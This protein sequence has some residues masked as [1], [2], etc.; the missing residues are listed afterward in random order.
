MATA[1]APE[2]DGSTTSAFQMPPRDRK[3][4]GPG[5]RPSPLG[6]NT[7]APSALDVALPACSSP[8]TSQGR[9][10]RRSRVARARHR[11]HSTRRGSSARGDRRHDPGRRAQAADE[12]EHRQPGREHAGPAPRGSAPGPATAATPYPTRTGQWP[13]GQPLHDEGVPHHDRHRDQTCHDAR[14][15]RG[16]RHRTRRPPGEAAAPAS[17]GACHRGPRRGRRPRRRRGR[18]RAAQCRGRARP[19]RGAGP[20]PTPCR[21]SGRSP[22][23]VPRR[24]AATASTR[25]PGGRP[26]HASAARRRPIDPCSHGGDT[27]GCAACP[28]EHATVRAPPPGPVAGSA[29][30]W[31]GSG[32]IAVAMM[33]MN[34]ATYGFT[35]P[36]HGS[37]ARSRTARSSR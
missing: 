24:A 27:L 31:P 33:L 20:A 34:V 25:S 22:V 35:M 6:A 10:A 9:L 15:A 32:Q 29:A 36:P 19:L 26:Q 23:R 5:R 37:S 7:S 28:H 21:S 4:S 17:A 14:A 12:E 2:R 3:A 13:I 16:R 8:A 1:S 11:R 18:P 30:C